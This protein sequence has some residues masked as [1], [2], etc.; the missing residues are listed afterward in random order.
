MLGTAPRRGRL[1]IAVVVIAATMT[2]AACGGG[3]GTAGPSPIAPAPRPSSSATIAILSPTNGDVVT[4]D[5]VK[6]K[7]SLEGAKIVPQTST[8]IRPD[9]GHIHLLL[10]GDV[11]SMNYGL[12]DTIGVTPGQHVLRTE[13]V[14][15]DHRPFEPRVFTEVVFEVKA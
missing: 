10:D 5:R 3:S 15:A 12:D 13:F 7:I 4:G 6:V 14:A 8:N 1:T 2:L 9:E 11:V